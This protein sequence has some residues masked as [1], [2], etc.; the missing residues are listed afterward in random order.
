MPDRCWVGT[1]DDALDRAVTSGR[2]SP[3]DADTIRDFGA[4]LRE[5]HDAE[6]AGQDPRVAA[7]D[8]YLRIF[9]P[10]GGA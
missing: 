2:V 10:E 1:D 5:V 7:R 4:F 6:Q 8:A 3:G 9:E